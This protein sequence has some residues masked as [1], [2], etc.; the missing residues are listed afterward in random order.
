MIS[1][2]AASGKTVKSIK[3]QNKDINL[4]VFAASLPIKAIYPLFKFSVRRPCFGHAG[5][6][7]RQKRVK[8]TDGGVECWLSV[9]ASA[10]AHNLKVT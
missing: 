3:N 7:V 2:L 9:F 8:Q 4:Y 1:F 5:S 10:F 6:N